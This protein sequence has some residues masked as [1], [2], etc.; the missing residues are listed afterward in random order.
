MGRIVW[1][2]ESRA[3]MVLG[4]GVPEP[5]T[6]SLAS[7]LVK[8]WWN[9]V[10]CT[11]QFFLPQI[12]MLSKTIMLTYTASV[13]E[14]NINLLSEPIFPTIKMHH[15]KCLIDDFIQLFQFMLNPY[16]LLRMLLKWS[17]GN[18]QACYCCCACCFSLNFKTPCS[19]FT[20]QFFISPLGIID[21]SFH[22]F[23]NQ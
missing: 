23:F 1:A 12:Q 8:R 22:L 3:E 13:D 17:Y 15:F 7:M 18:C 5:C 21:R 6:L 19:I 10:V 16:H 4:R 14:T 2:E 9:Y 20:F 11:H